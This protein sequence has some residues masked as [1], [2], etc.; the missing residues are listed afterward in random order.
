VILGEA[1]RAIAAAESLYSAGLL[2]QP[3]R[4]PTVPP[5]QSRLRITLSAEHSDEEV[6]RLA[7]VVTRQ[8]M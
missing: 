1:A 4:P 5:A 2:V 8:S 7:E 3:I 6:E